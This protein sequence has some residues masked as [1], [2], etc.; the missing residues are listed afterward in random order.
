VEVNEAL[1]TGEADALTKKADAELFSGSFVTSGTAAARVIH[2]GK[3]NY[4]HQ[5][6]HEAQKIKK[7]K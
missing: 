4:I 1:L 6:A 3:D 5:L 7:Q 2:V